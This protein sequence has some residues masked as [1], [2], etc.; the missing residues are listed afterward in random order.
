MENQNSK[1]DVSIVI[2]T[3]NEEKWLNFVFLALISQNTTID[4]VIIIDSG[5]IDKTLLIAEKYNAK[6]IRIPKNQFTH[7]Y[8]LNI[9]FETCQSSFVVSLSGHAI[10][11]SND[12]LSKLISHFNDSN[13][14]AVSSKI[15]GHGTGTSLQSVLF[16]LPFYINLRP[17]KNAVSLLWNTSTVYRHAMWKRNRFNENINICEDRAWALRA[18]SLGHDFVYEPRSIVRHYHKEPTTLFIKRLLA[19][20]NA[21]LIIHRNEKNNKYYRNE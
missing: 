2:R 15:V 9:G 6:I 21:I 3:L 20:L 7:G 12:W 11:A 10:P 13:I 1:S 18:R 19:T 16:S 17:R 5:S 8:A 14:A 4:D